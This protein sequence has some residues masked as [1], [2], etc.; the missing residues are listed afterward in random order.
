MTMT[1]LP[2]RPL[3]LDAVVRTPLLRERTPRRPDYEVENRALFA[4]V[5][6][7]ANPPR[8]ILQR[9]VETALELCQAGS[10]GISIIEDHL[11][12]KVF[13]WH[14]LAGALAAHKWGT[15]PRDFSPCGTVIDRNAVQLMRLPERHFLYLTNVKPQ[16]VEVLLVPF[17]V[18]AQPVGTIWVVAHDER[19][20]DAEDERLVKELGQL[21]A[22]AYQFAFSVQTSKL[23]DR[24]KDEFLATLA[25]QLRSP[26]LS[27]ESAKPRQL[28]SMKRM[29]T[30][31]L[32]RLRSSF[33]TIAAASA[34]SL[35]DP[36]SPEGQGVLAQVPVAPR[37]HHSRITFARSG[38]ALL[39]HGVARDGGHHRPNG[40]AHQ[41]ALDAVALLARMRQGDQRAL[42]ELYDCTAGSV[43]ALALAILRSE[44]DAEEVVGDTYAGA[45]R[46]SERFDAER[47]SPIGWLMMMCRSRAIDRLRHNRARGSARTVALESVCDI[48][49][50]A[51]SPEDLLSLFHNG[52][53]VQ[54]A[55]AML[56]PQRLKLVGLAFFEGLSAPEI[57]ERTGMP[58]GTVKS[59]IRRALVELRRNLQ[60]IDTRPA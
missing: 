17:S 21:A 37:A 29:I 55:L 7:L 20:F 56:G 42:E 19:Q 43:Y 9:L 49:E 22:E 45:W 28:K 53:R 11:G 52:S 33:E 58:L 34:L 32:D 35:D 26:L 18:D 50:D 14:A 30:D 59:H 8:D 15:T 57:A 44:Q 36:L 13:R 38:A 25:C 47:A 23:H 3:E 40:C 10:A 27:V 60:S 48:A 12:E 1:P 24:R 46:Q 2:E 41:P 6:A 16:V 39:P 54:V 31:L 51:L 4:L 5:Q